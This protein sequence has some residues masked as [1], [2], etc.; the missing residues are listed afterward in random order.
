ML[1]TPRAFGGCGPLLKHAC[2]FPE[3]TTGPRPKEVS[4]RGATPLADNDY[5]V[6]LWESINGAV[7]RAPAEHLPR[8]SVTA[9]GA[10]PRKY[11][12]PNPSTPMLQSG[13]LETFQRQHQHL[14]RGTA[15]EIKQFN[16]SDILVYPS[17]M[18]AFCGWDSTGTISESQDRGLR[19]RRPSKG[20]GLPP[21]S[22]PTS[23]ITTSTY[24]S[25]STTWSQKLPTKL[26]P[27]PR[28]MSVSSHTHPDPMARCLFSASQRV[29]KQP[30]VRRLANSFGNRRAASFF[31]VQS[32]STKW[33]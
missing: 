10:L 14:R 30:K 31:N 9:S 12:Q 4:P 20:G 6:R 29:Q 8:S 28:S 13:K 25:C 17:Y 22:P 7:R 1:A 18:G 19:H 23:S 24:G 26:Q 11:E 21:G 16:D 2:S 3:Y 27:L 15:K 33:Y 32:L 5:N